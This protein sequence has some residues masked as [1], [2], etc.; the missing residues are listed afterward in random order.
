M[1]KIIIL[2]LLLSIGSSFSSTCIIY[3][4]GI[5][6]PHCAKT[7]PVIFNQK[8]NQYNLTIIEYEIYQSRG[9][10]P[11]MTLYHQKYNTILGI[12]QIIFGN[13][14]LI[15]GDYPIL[16][17]I[18]SKL[19][20]E[21]G[22]ECLLIDG[23]K[24]FEDVDFNSLPGS[25]KIW[26]KDKLI[27]KGSQKI[28]NKIVLDFFFKNVTPNG[29]KLNLI[30]VPYSGGS[31]TFKNGVQYKDWIFLWGR[32][33]KSGKLIV[34]NQVISKYRLTLPIVTSLAITDSINPCALA[35]LASMLLMITTYN[36]KNKRKVLYAGI[37]FTITVFFMYFIYGLIIIKAF[38]FIQSLVLIKIWL[39]KG[40]AIF[41]LIIGI[42]EIKD[43]LHYKKGTP[44]TEMPL[45]FRPKVQR[46]LK[47]VTSPQ[48]AALIGAF[49]TLF[50]LPCTMGPYVITG[51]ILSGLEIIKAI[52][53][54]FYY[55]LLFVL[56]MITITIAVY[57][58]ISR[59]ED[60]YGWRNENIR[61]LHGIAGTL[62]VIVALL[63]IF[64][65]I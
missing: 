13:G 64:G 30:S 5:G 20:E 43:F 4:T 27:I 57:L 11:I 47:K 21:N 52:P 14:N 60:V 63:I 65:F 18:D 7:D 6:C 17:N 39:Y 42:L 19:K 48:S 26:Y 44:L 51:G 28:N 15:A 34:K 8:L 54:L 58:G 62:L 23:S 2:L 46:L 3:F 1:R 29:T 56:P 31:I 33:S 41:A 37:A 59:V 9:N 32:S 10:A 55:N 45:S 22:S 38:Q 12:P 35:V 36:P 53:W 25:P 40:L 50:L 61:K 16:N 49:V 24:K